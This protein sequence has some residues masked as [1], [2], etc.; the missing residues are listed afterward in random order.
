VPSISRP[1]RLRA[2]ARATTKPRCAV[3]P[4][5]LLQGRLL[6]GLLALA[7]MLSFEGGAFA[8]EEDLDDLMG[9]FDDEFDAS[10]IGSEDNALHPWLA[11]L[12]YGEV[13]AERV[14][15]SGSI[16]AGVVYN[17]LD[18]SV[19]H[20]DEPAR[21]THY[22]NLSRLDLDG[23]LQLDVELP[24]DWRAR[25][26]ALGWYDLSYRA[27][28]RGSYGG[29]VIDVYEW[30]VDSGEVYVAGP[31]TEEIDLA[32]G[33][34]IVNWGRSDTFRIVDVVN[35]IDN[36]EPGLVDIED[37]RRPRAMVKI[38]AATGP[39]SATLLVIPEHRYD[40]QPPPGSDFYPDL[41]TIPPLFRQTPIQDDSDFRGTPGFAAKMGGNFSGWDFTLYG[42]YI[43]EST[44]VLDVS[45]AGLRRES[46]R[47]SLA[48]GAGNYT[49]DRWLFKIETAFLHDL[50]LLR[51]SATS[52][53]GVESDH[54]DRFD[55]MVGVELY[56]PDNL[57]VA[58][59]VVNR[60]LIGSTSDVIS[61]T[62]T[63]EQSRFET[64]LRISRPFFRERLD[65][66][67]LGLAI[68]ERFHR[69][70]LLR[71]SG[72]FEITDSWAATGGILMFIGGPDDGIGAFDSNDRI[73]AELK[74]SF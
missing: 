44:R 52:P 13:I 5:C 69:G 18:H 59:E 49:I 4:S 10:E 33:R 54:V 39:W 28:G 56:G 2:S 27:Q 21:R 24:G 38:D 20:G 22:G 60:H 36:K 68:G 40:R 34:K 35:P 71:L 17:Y 15:L 66:T 3:H 46:N 47:F 31:I 16:S 67:L 62:Q 43:D 42:A 25:A 63:A 37:L 74:Y 50:S 14:D 55:T 32:V 51:T 26:E 73:Y 48:G 58:L 72:D 8:D 65:I 19:T 6:Q 61:S 29:A 70:G 7:L 23:F 30:Q 53:F 11:A 1:C 9:G 57:V 41:A 12:P 64:A 45:A